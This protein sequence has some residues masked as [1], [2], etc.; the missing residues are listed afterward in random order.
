MQGR[1]VHVVGQPCWWAAL[2]VALQAWLSTP[3][4]SHLTLDAQSSP[5]QSPCLPCRPHLCMG[6]PLDNYSMTHGSLLLWLPACASSGTGVCVAWHHVS[7]EC[8]GVL[9]AQ[10][11]VG[12]RALSACLWFSPLGSI[13]RVRLDTCGCIATAAQHVIQALLPAKAHVS[14]WWCS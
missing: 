5:I 12:C 3:A 6:G 11:G 9:R 2:V 10:R 8:L 4:G 1:L 13:S 7:N 14:A